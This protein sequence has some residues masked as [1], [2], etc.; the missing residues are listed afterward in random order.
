MALNI[1]S[2]EANH[3]ARQLAKE[4]G[5]SLT[6]AVTEALR[7]RLAHTRRQR[8]DIASRLMAIRRASSSRT[9]LDERTDEEILGYNEHGLPG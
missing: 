3:L 1:K 7:Q 2:V 8:R 5:G 9:L 4:T 6:D